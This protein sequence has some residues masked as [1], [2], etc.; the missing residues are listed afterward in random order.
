MDDD[1]IKDIFGD[2]GKTY[3]N[4]LDEINNSLE[5]NEYNF[6]KNLDYEEELEA[7]IA[8]GMKI[9]WS[10]MLQRCHLASSATLIRQKRWVE[11]V[12]SAASQENFIAFA[13]TFRGLIESAG[14]SYHSLGSVPMTLAN[15]YS[16]IREAVKGS[17][18]NKSTMMSEELEDML[19]HFTHGRKLSK[20]EKKQLPESHQ[21]KSAYKY[22]TE[23]EEGS[24]AEVDKCYKELC[25]IVHPALL[26]VSS[27]LDF[28]TSGK[29]EK[30]KVIAGRDAEHIQDFIDKYSNVTTEVFI[31]PVN[32]ALI[33]LKTLNK[34]PL[35]RIHTEA[36]RDI[37]LRDIPL[38]NKVRQK[39]ESKP[40][41]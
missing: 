18:D 39:I 1:I 10:E 34:F 25:G 14:D 21:A 19:I 7:D 29:F 24:Q 16:E 5:G 32:S 22:R 9:Y 13:A 26:S 41:S 28:T 6:M 8:S 36:V 2:I 30:L 40:H 3:I 31:K 38:W 33:T 4:I 23:L 11:G 35:S 27:F 17:W 12:L 37:G 20:K 15:N